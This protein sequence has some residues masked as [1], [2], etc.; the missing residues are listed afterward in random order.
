[1]KAEAKIQAHFFYPI[2]PDFF[3]DSFLTIPPQKIRQAARPYRFKNSIFSAYA[4]CRLLT[5]R[6]FYPRSV[7]KNRSAEMHC[8][9]NSG[10]YI[11]SFKF[12][13]HLSVFCF[14]LNREQRA[15]VWLLSV[16][17]VSKH[18][19]P[20]IFS[21]AQ[22][23]AYRNQKEKQPPSG[24]RSGCIYPCSLVC[25]G[26]RLP[27]ENHALRAVF[28]ESRTVIHNIIIRFLFCLVNGIFYFFAFWPILHN[29][30]PQFSL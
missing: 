26:N 20:A 3:T 17:Y 8:S 22:Q 28:P 25:T 10:A 16:P 6:F 24:F 12:R 23:A 27:A 29:L 13:Q 4:A 30:F 14:P 5:F 15:H 11:L 19:L 2:P 1:M 21:S 9:G 18:G 7:F